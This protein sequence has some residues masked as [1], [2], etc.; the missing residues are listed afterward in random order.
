[1][2]VIIITSVLIITCIYVCVSIN[3]HMLIITC[4]LIMPL[5]A[6]LSVQAWSAKYNPSGARIV[7][8]SD[9]RGVHI[10]DCAM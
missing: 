8:V 1:M 7:S 5:I 2:S 6:V 10:Y 4:V 3:N 9:D